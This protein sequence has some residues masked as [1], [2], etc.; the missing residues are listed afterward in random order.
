MNERSNGNLGVESSNGTAVAEEMPLMEPDLRLEFDQGAMFIFPFPCEP[1]VRGDVFINGCQGY[2]KAEKDCLE[3][4][5]VRHDQKR[6]P[7][8]KDKDYP[9]DCLKFYRLGAA[10][11]T[12]GE[13][14]DV[15]GK[16]VALWR[17]VNGK[18]SI[19]TDED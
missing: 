2:F 18:R 13:V 7:N 17:V 14:M 9:Q 11:M 19:P 4:K 8:T 6:G 12:A 15:L 1:P 16:L 10:T 5:I 3:F